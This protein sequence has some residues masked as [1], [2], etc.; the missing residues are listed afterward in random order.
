V[1]AS[2][3]VVSSAELGLPAFA[4]SVLAALTA[5]WP[6]AARADDTTAE[7]VFD[8]GVKLLNE[9]KYDEACST[10]DRAVDLAG[11]NAVGGLLLLGE[12]REKQGRPASAWAVYRRAFAA[13]H[14]QNDARETKASDAIARLEPTLPRLVVHVAPALAARQDLTIERGGAPL[15]REAWDVA[16]PVDPGSVEIVAELP[17]VDPH[18]ERIDVAAGPKTYEAKVEPWASALPPNPPPNPNPKPPPDVTPSGLRP[19]GMAGI[20]VGSVGAIGLFTGIGIGFLAQSD[21]VD[22]FAD[23]ANQCSGNLC[24][25]RGKDAIDAARSKG[26]I[27]TGVAIGGAILLAGGATMLIVDIATR[28]GHSSTHALELRIGPSGVALAGSLPY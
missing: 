27:G 2:P 11:G 28:G 5:I 6:D 12:C 26:N 8:E 9:G 23:P 13:A 25:Q 7:A 24:N 15:P 14:Q 19:V 10:L 17:G 1:R 4:I 3:R 16:L 21:Y 22:A 20:V 18:H